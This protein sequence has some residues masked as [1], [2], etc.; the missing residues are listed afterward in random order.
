MIPY[1]RESNPESC[2]L[3]YRVGKRYISEVGQSRCT[4]GLACGKET[5]MDGLY[6]Q[7][8]RKKA[9]VKSRVAGQVLKMC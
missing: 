6:W 7:I 5:V 9:F 2:L 3:N 8:W 4:T 1:I